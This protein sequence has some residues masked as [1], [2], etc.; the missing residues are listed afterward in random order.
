MMF[1]I[2]DFDKAVISENMISDGIISLIFK[3]KV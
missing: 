1:L 3:K 2:F